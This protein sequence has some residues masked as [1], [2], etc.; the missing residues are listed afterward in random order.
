MATKRKPKVVQ[1]GE[2]TCDV[3]VTRGGVQIGL[4]GIPLGQAV[5][6][7][8]YILKG[9]EQ[10]RGAFPELHAPYTVEQIGGYTPVDTSDDDTWAR[11]QVGF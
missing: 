3:Q 2:L 6:V 10:K 11:R 5:D 9:L 7:A 1:I 4:G 8:C